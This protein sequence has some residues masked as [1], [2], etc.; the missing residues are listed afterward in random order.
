MVVPTVGSV[1]A[2]A[3]DV[4]VLVLV[5][6]VVFVEFVAGG[7]WHALARRANADSSAAQK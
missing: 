7:C 2:L 4:F 6:F 1:L 3:V 5:V